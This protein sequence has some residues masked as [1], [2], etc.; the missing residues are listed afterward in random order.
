MAKS[1]AEQVAE[2]RSDL[3]I[4]REDN[5]ILRERLETL[6][7]DVKELQ[8]ERKADAKEL[9]DLRQE[10]ALLRQHLEAVLR[11]VKELQGERKADSTEIKELRQENA[12]LRQRLDDHFKRVDTWSGRLWALIVV[13]IGAVMSLASGLIISLNRK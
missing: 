5:A 8:G 2:L 10:N 11:D 6:L 7:R 1:P 9:K 4:V 13:L 12:L 3:T